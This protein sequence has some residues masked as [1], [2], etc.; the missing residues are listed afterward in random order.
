M[1]FH[2]TAIT[3][4]LCGTFAFAF[5]VGI[6]FLMSN[7]YKHIIYVPLEHWNLFKCVTNFISL[8]AYAVIRYHWC[9]RSTHVNYIV[10]TSMMSIEDKL[11]V[12]LYIYIHYHS[13]AQLNQ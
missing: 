8:K 2:W 1:H 5:V 3:D 6:S 9:Q 10:Q 12:G 4:P 11:N 13:L 7:L